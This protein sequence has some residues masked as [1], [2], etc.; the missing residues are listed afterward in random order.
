MPDFPAISR[1]GMSDQKDSPANPFAAKSV[2]QNIG[3]SS[4]K[5]ENRLSPQRVIPCGD[6]VGHADAVSV[7]LA[8]PEHGTQ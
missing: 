3:F 6:G 7:G 5:A 8:S 4:L 1:L 2:C